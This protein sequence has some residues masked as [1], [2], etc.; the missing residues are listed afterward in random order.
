MTACQSRCKKAGTRSAP[1]I[2][3]AFYDE[4]VRE[5][6]QPLATEESKEE[7]KTG[8]FVRIGFE[9]YEGKGYIIKDFKKYEG[10]AIQLNPDTVSPKGADVPDGFN[11]QC[12]SFVRFFGLPQTTTWKKGPRVCDLKPDQLPEGTVV[13]TMR[14]GVYHSDTYGRSHVGIYLEHDDYAEYSRNLSD[15]AGIKIM[16]QWKGALIDS[17]KKKYSVDADKETY[18]KADWTDLQGVKHEHRTNWINDGEEY[19][20]V[21]AP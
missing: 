5:E 15:T 3:C 6:S 12:V 20:V 1:G 17:R 4:V 11:N 8:A 19:Y 10:C 14:D 2:K 21:L 16:D 7:T 13:A 18:K 9:G